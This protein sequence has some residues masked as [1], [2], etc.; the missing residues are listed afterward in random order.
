MTLIAAGV[1]HRTAP[2]KQRER[3]ALGNGDLP[4]ALLHFRKEYGNGV[5]LSTCNRTEVYVHP[6]HDTNEVPPAELMSQLA[7]L[8]GLDP[9]TGLPRFYELEGRAVAEHLFAVA[10]GVDSMILGEGQILGQVRSAFSAAHQAGSLDPVLARLFHDALRTGKRARSETP[11]AR[12]A[13]SV[14][15]AAVNLIRAHVPPLSECRALVVGAGDAGKLTARAL[16][17]HGVRRITVT[18]R[19]ERR[20]EEV[21]AY[22]EGAVLPFSRLADGLAEADLVITCSSAPGFVVA[23]ALVKEAVSRRT[24]PITFMD[25]AVPR[26]VDPKVGEIP[27]VRLFDIDNLQAVSEANL[28]LREEAAEDVRAIVRRAARD[29]DYWLDGRRAVPTIKALVQ[30]A[31]AVRHAELERTLR[32]LRL[33]AQTAEKLDRMTAAIIKKLLHEPIAYLRYAD[34][35]WEA[36]QTVRSIF[37]VEDGAEDGQ[38][39]GPTVR[40]LLGV[41]DG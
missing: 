34:D 9:A 3:L 38:D 26:D 11:I 12:H 32:E 20:A 21:A 13:V 6:N 37:G 29:F 4:G 41:Q 28:K 31:E 5:L 39:G 35:S 40:R 10:A 22:L 23:L 18:S 16:R 19:T 15:S 1:S 14:S 25:V 2:L 17:D 8:R 24:T 27:G 36:A 7:R 33:D 30:R